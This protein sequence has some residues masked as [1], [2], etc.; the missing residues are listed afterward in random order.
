MA[1]FWVKCWAVIDAI[2]TDC[3][4]CAFGRGVVLGFVLSAVHNRLMA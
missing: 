3:P 2:T 1:K 4:L